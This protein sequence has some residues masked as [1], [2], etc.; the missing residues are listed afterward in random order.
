MCYII[1]YPC[2]GLDVSEE[3]RA[4]QRTTPRNPSQ[5]DLERCGSLVR[6]ASSRYA[7]DGDILGPDARIGGGFALDA[8]SQSTHKAIN[9]R[10]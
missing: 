1:C 6:N 4:A 7:A 3:G 8:V 10:P 5:F 2:I 9:H